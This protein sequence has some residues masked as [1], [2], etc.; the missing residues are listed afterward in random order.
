MKSFIIRSQATKKLVWQSPIF[1]IL[2]FALFSASHVHAGGLNEVK[3]HGFL[4]Q[5][6]L[7]SDLNNYLAESTQGSA[8]FNEVGLT[9]S[10]SP[11]D[12]LRLGLQLLSRDLGDEGNNVAFLDWGYADYR[13]HDELG[14]RIGKIK[15]PVGLYNKS[16]DLDMLRQS[17]LLPQG[18]YGE[19][20]RQFILAINGLGLYG[21]KSVS[22]LGDFEYEFQVGSRN[23]PDINTEFWDSQYKEVGVRIASEIE[24]TMTQTPL[25]PPGS[26]NV[27]YSE[28]SDRVV[29]ASNTVLGSLIWAPPV[30]GV[31]VAGVYLL[32]SDINASGKN[33]VLLSIASS[34]PG[35]PSPASTLVIPMQSFVNVHAYTASAEYSNGGLLLAAEYLRNNWDIEVR[36]VSTDK[37]SH[38]SEGYYGSASFQVSPWLAFGGYY[39][40]F[41]P[42]RTDREGKKQVHAA[43]GWQKDIAVNT[44]FDITPYWI[45][46]LEFHIYDGFA[47]VAEPEGEDTRARNWVL[48]A[49]KNTFHF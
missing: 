40:E 32:T 47:L 48:L 39:S 24:Q 35:F 49:L 38:S 31:R 44:R 3:I 25:Y 12:R 46:K 20:T 10:I 27:A 8:E 42:D 22:F 34:T 30:K 28:T 23:I 43:A 5:G 36:T 7:W 14:F 29:Y 15:N 13:W 2:C 41:Y 21:Y 33:E 19:S 18:V 45:S 9:T 26:I 37:T 4:S 16:R 1:V 17:V 6:Y 11:C